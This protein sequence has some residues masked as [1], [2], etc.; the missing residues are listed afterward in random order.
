ML[1]SRGFHFPVRRI[2]E[3]SVGERVGWLTGSTVLGTSTEEAVVKEAIVN[4]RQQER[5]FRSDNTFDDRFK[6]IIRPLNDIVLS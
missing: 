5:L 2:P 4:C 6:G 3:E 1:W